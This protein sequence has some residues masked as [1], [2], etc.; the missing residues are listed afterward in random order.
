MQH[1]PFRTVTQAV[2]HSLRVGVLL[3]SVLMLCGLW[4]YGLHVPSDD[5]MVLIGL[6]F[7][8]FLVF[9]SEMRDALDLV[10][11]SHDATASA[12]TRWIVTAGTVISLAAIV[13]S[14]PLLLIAIARAVAPGAA[15]T[16]A[17]AAMF[18]EAVLTC[19]RHVRAHS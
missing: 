9:R 17:I 5:A 19:P 4:I 14:V 2:R 1:S 3:S 13:V 12:M 18:W 10:R 8:A 16:I 7:V 15:I 11:S 6:V